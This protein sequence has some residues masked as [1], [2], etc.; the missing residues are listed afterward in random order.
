MKKSV[1]SALCV[2]TA[3]MLPGAE[4]LIKN[5]DFSE[6]DANGVPK[7]WSYY[8][9]KDAKG[10]QCGGGLHFCHQRRYVGEISE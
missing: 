3:L 5:G 8:P 7:Y 6:V 4:N 9:K 1:I 10:S 2:L